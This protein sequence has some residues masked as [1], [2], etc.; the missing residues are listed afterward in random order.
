MSVNCTHC[1]NFWNCDTENIRMDLIK[2]NNSELGVD[3]YIVLN[4][5]KIKKLRNGFRNVRAFPLINIELMN[6]K[7][8][9]IPSNTLFIGYIVTATCERM[10]GRL[11]ILSDIH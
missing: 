10:K 3:Q 7:E 11:E 6:V 9:R 5:S 1:I 4:Q 8:F 2:S